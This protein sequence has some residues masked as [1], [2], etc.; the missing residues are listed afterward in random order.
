VFTVLEFEADDAVAD[1]LA[2]TL[3]GLLI[4]GPNWYA[5]FRAGAEHVVVF[6]GRIFRYAVG[7]QDGRAAAVEYGRQLGIP[8]SQ[9]DW[10]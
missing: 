4:E 9:L 7:D 5:D 2:E 1:E 3:A 10:R 6:P 8:E